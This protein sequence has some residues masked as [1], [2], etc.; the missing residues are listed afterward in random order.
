MKV[1]PVQVTRRFER[2]IVLQVEHFRRWQG[3][4]PDSG[5]HLERALVLLR[6]E[7]VPMLARNAERGKPA[8]WLNAL[9]S[10]IELAFLAEIQAVNTATLSQST[11][12]REWRVGDFHLLYYHAA[13][14]VYLASLRHGK[15]E[16][17][18]KPKS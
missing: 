4:F 13:D 2:S 9:D 10:S 5:R 1:L 7:I 6:D 3:R 16:Q 18:F 8:A 14:A 12:V 11:V 17:F 15:Q